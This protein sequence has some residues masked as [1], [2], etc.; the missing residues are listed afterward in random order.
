M[1]DAIKL[2]KLKLKTKRAEWQ[3]EREQLLLDRVFTPGVIRVLLMAGL[4]A[5]ATHEARSPDN[6]GPVRS[7][8]AFALPGIGVPMLAA[9]SGIKDKYALAAISAASV[10]YVTGQM[11][12]GW[13]DVGIFPQLPSPNSVMDFLNPFD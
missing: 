2:E 1:T 4:L 3:H 6:I 12:K 13:Q 10:G 5:Y 11:I 7:T 8:L 9:E